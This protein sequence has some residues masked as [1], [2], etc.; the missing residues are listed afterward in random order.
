MISIS[1]LAAIHGPAGSLDVKV[2][3]TEPFAISVNEGVNVGFNAAFP[4]KNTP[5]LPDHV[6][7]TAEPPTDPLRII[8]SPSHITSSTPAETIAEVENEI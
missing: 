3:V 4:G 7:L 6:P 2:K 8:S 5:A 1:S